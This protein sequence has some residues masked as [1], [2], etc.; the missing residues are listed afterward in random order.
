[1][2]NTPAFN[3]DWFTPPVPVRFETSKI[4]KDELINFK[5][6]KDWAETLNSSLESSLELQR[7]DAKHPFNKFPY[8]V[9]S[10]TIQSADK[11][12]S[13]RVHLMSSNLNLIDLSLNISLIF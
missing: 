2:S 9:R 3:L 4:S 5:P 1:M 12:G 10:V 13:T 11:F 7:A 6:F 8:S